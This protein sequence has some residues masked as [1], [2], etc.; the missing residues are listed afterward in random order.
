V[1][2]PGGKLLH[3]WD[4]SLQRL[5]LDD[6]LRSCRQVAL[7]GS[8]EIQLASGVG[9]ILFYKGSETSIVFRDGSAHQGA[10]A[11]ERLRAAFA[12]EEGT[13]TVYEL[14]LDM[15]H[16]LRGLTNRRRER[17]M[18]SPE[19]LSKLLDELREREHTGLLE[20]QTG[21][22]A[23]AL[24]FVQGRLSNVYWE[25][26][27]GSTLDKEPARATLVDALNGELATVFASDFSRDV[28][29][30]RREV[31]SPDQAALTGAEP[32][33]AAIPSAE[34][35]ARLRADLLR[36][37]DEQVPAMVQ[38]LVFDLMTRAILARRVRGTAAL[39]SMPI[40]ER[41]PEMTAA[42]REAHAMAGDDIDFVRI[43][44]GAT[45]T[46]I[47]LVAPT[48]EGIGL[49]IDRAQPASQVLETLIRLARDYE[50]RT[51]AARG[52]GGS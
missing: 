50:A 27:D 16:L 37:L 51:V 33:L 40:A 3:G 41:I 32:E 38:A 39:A 45:D 43:E 28:W 29:K 34:G 15:A 48:A 7:T 12:S 11:L 24:L 14:P 17:T 4:L 20:V 6:L 42:L 25:G 8:A 47:A 13:I 30:S 49:V 23:A 19:D 31:S 2:F 5:S 18:L 10:A 9:M 36:Q 35:E 22:G 46:L 1:K 44:A 26:T 21:S 52:A